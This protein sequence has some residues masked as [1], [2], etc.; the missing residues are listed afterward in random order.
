MA[1][2]DLELRG[3]GQLRRTAAACIDDLQRMDEEP[4]MADKG[5]VPLRRG[6]GVYWKHVEGLAPIGLS[7]MAEAQTDELFIVQDGAGA[8]ECLYHK[9]AC[10]ALR[11]V[12]QRQCFLDLK[13]AKMDGL[14]VLRRRKTDLDAEQPMGWCRPRHRRR[15]TC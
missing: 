1:R 6:D 13:L 9:G 5:C 14:E 11:G 10:E 7:A 8:L 4:R 12:A 3:E 2:R 15:G